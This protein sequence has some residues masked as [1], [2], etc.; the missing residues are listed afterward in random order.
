MYGRFKHQNIFNQIKTTNQIMVVNIL[1][2][3]IRMDS[4]HY[5]II[6]LVGF[7]LIHYVINFNVVSSFIIFSEFDIMF[8]SN[9]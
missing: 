3:R 8:L 7:D 5:K 6:K 4:S 1:Y 2:N 9:I